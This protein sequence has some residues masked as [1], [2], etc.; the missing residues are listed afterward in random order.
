VRKALRLKDL[1]PMRDDAGARLRRLRLR[2]GM[3]LAVLAGRCGVSAAFLSMVENGHREL[4]RPAHII[5]L[6]GALGACPLYLAYGT[7]AGPGGQ[8]SRPPLPAPFPA[9]ADSATLRRHGLLAGE[10]AG[11]LA[12]GDGRAAGDWLRRIARDPGVSPWLLIDQLAT[13]RTGD[14]ISARLNDSGPRPAPPCPG[15]GRLQG[16]YL[17]GRPPAKS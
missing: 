8:V 9:L 3:P 7:A 5:A 15:A 2:R 1:D 4:Q 17:P 11:F 12:R 14:M 13:R 16:K 10:F 6:A